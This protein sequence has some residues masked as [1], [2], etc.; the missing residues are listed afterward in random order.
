[1]MQC[2][3]E[4]SIRDNNKTGATQERPAVGATQERPASHAWDTADTLK[5]ALDT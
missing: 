3:A 5:A 4:M 1:M 2:Y